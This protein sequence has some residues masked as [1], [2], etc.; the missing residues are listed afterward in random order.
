MNGIRC[1]KT[2]D[3]FHR[4]QKQKH[5]LQKEI[6]C[7]HLQY[8]IF[9]TYIFS[10]DFA[11]KQKLINPYLVV[12][13]ENVGESSNPY[14]HDY[15][16]FLSAPTTTTHPISKSVPTTLTEEE[17]KNLVE[18]K[19]AQMPYSKFDYIPI[20]HTEFSSSRFPANS[21]LQL[22]AE[23]GST[24]H[25]QQP[26]K[27]DDEHDPFSLDAPRKK[28]TGASSSRQEEAS[29]NEFYQRKCEELLSK[30]YKDFQNSVIDKKSGAM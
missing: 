17:K 8:F 29:K 25:Q 18:F 26:E 15:E 14:E 30:S 24:T 27:K 11:K 16:Q 19:P 2:Q 3:Q 23:N 9:L 20:N 12:V 1:I 6:V 4:G 28:S 22:A 10:I 21:S 13:K 5:P 7:N